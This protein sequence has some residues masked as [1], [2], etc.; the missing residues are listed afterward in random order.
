MP[1]GQ[2]REDHI[3]EL[4]VSAYENGAWK[5]A[6]LTFPDKLDDGGIDG[7]AK[8]ADGAALALEHTVIEPFLGDIADQVE[9]LP[10]FPLIENDKSLLVPGVWIQ[11]FVPVGTLHLPTPRAR[12]AVV[13]AVHSWLRTNR[14]SLPKGESQ[15]VCR[16]QGKPDFEITLNLSLTDIPGDGALHVR[17]QQMRDTLGEVIEKMLTKKLPKLVEAASSKRALLLERRHMNLYPRRILAEIEKRRP[18]FPA[19]ADVHEIWIAEKI[20]FFQANDGDVRFERFVD[21]RVV[22]SFDFQDDVL[23]HQNF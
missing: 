21:G 14:T 18:A 16:V 7:L 10:I 4:F 8:R 2:R 3:I 1:T 11:V 15:G 5:N 23:Q 9:M 20:E 17:R 22:Q 13:G 12:E 19:L 6:H